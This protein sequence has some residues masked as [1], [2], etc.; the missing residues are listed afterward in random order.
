MDSFIAFYKTRLT[1]WKPWHLFEMDKIYQDENKKSELHTIW[2]LNNDEKSNVILRQVEQYTESQLLQ[3]RFVD[4]DRLEECHAKIDLDS[5]WLTCVQT[6]A[7]F[8]LRFLYSPYGHETK[9]LADIWKESKQELKEHENFLSESKARIDSVKRDHAHL[10]NQVKIV[11]NLVKQTVKLNQE[12][13]NGN[14]KKITPEQLTVLNHA[15]MGNIKVI[16]MEQD[17]FSADISDKIAK[18]QAKILNIKQSTFEKAAQCLKDLTTDYHEQLKL[19]PEHKK[20][21]D[22]E[23]QEAKKE[24][25][26]H[27]WNFIDLLPGTVKTD[28]IC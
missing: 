1:G 15:I 17:K 20:S 19:Y 10:S 2:E 5:E 7:K 3:G 8:Q 6:G 21:I 4:D 9:T 26:D 13:K 11:T 14:V 28:E 22:T 25:D 23:F 16:Q 27:V 12:F 24:M 18:N